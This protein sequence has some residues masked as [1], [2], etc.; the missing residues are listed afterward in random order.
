MTAHAGAGLQDV[1]A[2]VHI[3][4]ADDLVHVHVVVTADARELIGKGDV[5]GAEGILDDLGHFGRPDVRNDD[6]T[7]AEAGVAGLDFLPYRLVIGTDRAVVVEEFIDHVA[8]DDA[9][10][11]MD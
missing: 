11:G 5:H 9:L 7:L 3:A 6:F 8:G 2:R 10:G 1:H 4:D